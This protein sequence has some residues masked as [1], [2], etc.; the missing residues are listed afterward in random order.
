MVKTCPK[1]GAKNND[2]MFWCEKCKTNLMEGKEFYIT[3]KTKK[4]QRS[5]PP[6]RNELKKHYMEKVMQS[7]DYSFLYEKD[8]I[9]IKSI[10]TIGAFIVAIII[11]AAMIVT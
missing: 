3:K 2:E 5:T 8:E 6:T 9:N 10:I 7:Q 4:E 1:C 11:V